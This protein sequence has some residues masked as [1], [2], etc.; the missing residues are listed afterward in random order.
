MQ[1]GHPSGLHGHMEVRSIATKPFSPTIFTTHLWISKFMTILD[2]LIGLFVCLAVARTQ[3]TT[4]AQTN[5]DNA[6]PKADFMP[7]DFHAFYRRLYP[8]V[9]E[10][11][12]LG[13]FS[14]RSYLPGLL[15]DLILLLDVVVFHLHD[16]LNVA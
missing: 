14:C 1:I 8:E 10:R 11:P 5:A 13:C 3:G 7:L 6:L 9:L 16:S 15:N 2:P 12:K 4:Q